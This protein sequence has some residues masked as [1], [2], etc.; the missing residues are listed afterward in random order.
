MRRKIEMNF[1]LMTAE[2]MSLKV[3]HRQSV[4]KKL[5]HL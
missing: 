3:G 2:C 1:D 5:T 4:K